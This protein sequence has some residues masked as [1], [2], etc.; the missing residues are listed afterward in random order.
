MDDVLIEDGVQYIESTLTLMGRQPNSGADPHTLTHSLT[1]SALQNELERMCSR[2]EI[3]R[4]N[5]PVFQKVLYEE[6]C[7]SIYKGSYSLV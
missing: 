7:S 2:E 3:T 6:H 4:G 1:C 5:Y